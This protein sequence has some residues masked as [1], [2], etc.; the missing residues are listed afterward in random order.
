MSEYFD[1]KSMF[2]E[3][4]VSQYNNHMVMTNVSKQTRKKFINI[5]TK[6]CDEYANNRTNPGNPSYNVA[7]YNIT[8]PEK[9]NDVKSMSVRNVEIPIT[10]YNIS[11]SAGNNFF[12]I[13][14]TSNSASYMITLDDGQYDVSSLA[15]SINAK[16]DAISDISFVN[17]SISNNISQFSCSANAYTIQFAV[18]ST[19]TFDKY[20]V[21]SKLGWMLGYRNIAYGITT[22]ASVR[23]ESIVNLLGSKYLYLAIDEFSKGNQTSF[24]SSLAGSQI[25][26]YI[27]GKIILNKATF[28]F[29]TILPA[30]NYDGYLMTDKRTYNG[31]IDIQKLNVQLLDENGSLVN[32]NG[33]DFSFCIEVDYE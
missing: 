16:M 15:S 21:K 11:A 17:F 20:N 32:L 9:I 19:G 33:I 8:L 31:K 3:P 24:I 1:E 2:M 10:F 5:D 26:K 13:T 30:N 7:N 28:P 6:F 22:S 25:N 27:I 12:Q 23:S 18:S 4:R 29:G 14:R